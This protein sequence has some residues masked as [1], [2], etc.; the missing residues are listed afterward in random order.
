M[1]AR[2]GIVDKTMKDVVKFQKFDGVVLTFN[3]V[4]DDPSLGHS[5]MRAFNLKYYMVRRQRVHC[6]CRHPPFA[7]GR[8]SWVVAEVGNGC[9]C[10]STTRSRCWRSGRIRTW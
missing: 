10:R 7:A 8:A 9:A 6:R 3:C 5:G 2:M 1:M 4:W